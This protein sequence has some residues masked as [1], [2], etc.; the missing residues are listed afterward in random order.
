MRVSVKWEGEVARMM[1]QR[2]AKHKR[3]SSSS[4]S[5]QQQQRRRTFPNDVDKVLANH[6]WCSVARDA[7]EPLP[8]AENAAEIDVKHPPI[9]W[10]R[11][12]DGCDYW[13]KREKKQVVGR[14]SQL[15][16]QDARLQTVY[17]QARA[18][19]L[20]SLPNHT[21]TKERTG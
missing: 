2:S 19:I 21:R 5:Q 8:V 6:E 15:I 14:T 16:N 1:Q 13:I 10:K 3:S 20:P 4:S 17:L 9:A 18:R 11:E 12:R 7:Q